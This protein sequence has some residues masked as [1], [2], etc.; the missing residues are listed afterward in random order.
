M[1]KLV[2]TAAV[3][4]SQTTKEQTPFYVTPEEIAEEVYHCYNAGF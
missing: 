2:I 3:A 1:D 4:G